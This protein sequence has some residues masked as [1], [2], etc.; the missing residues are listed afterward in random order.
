MSTFSV[1]AWPSSWI[2]NNGFPED[3]LNSFQ[4]SHGQ[5]NVGVAF[6]GGGTRS[7]ACT[8]GQLKALH[9]LDIMKDVKYI[10]AVS[11]GAWA[12]TPYTFVD[13]LNF[14]DFFGRI[15]EPEDIDAKECS[16]SIP[17]SF[18]ECIVKSGI[19][20]KLIKAGFSGKGDESFAHVIGQIFLKPF[21]KHDPS[22][23]FTYNTE[24]QL[25]A[26]ENNNHKDLKFHIARE[27]APFLIVGA[28]L[29]NQDGVNF[30]KKYILNIPPIIAVSEFLILM[31]IYLLKMIFLAVDILLAWDTTVL[32]HIRKQS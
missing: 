25:E 15:S 31:K 19:I 11:G 6:S 1:K 27:S 18:Q 5:R 17:K 24:T 23:S 30:S 32:A 3:N 13:N 16:T 2:E 28:T 20:S 21:D 10:S 9:D 8:L 12:A 29:L 14:T 7:A 26:L 4:D 22:S